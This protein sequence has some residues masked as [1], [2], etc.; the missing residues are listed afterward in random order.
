MGRDVTVGDGDEMPLAR[1]HHL[2][3]E[4]ASEGVGCCEGASDLLEFDET[5]LL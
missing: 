1:R 4:G 2:F 3:A 5:I